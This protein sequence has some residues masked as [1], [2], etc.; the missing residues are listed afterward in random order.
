M[1]VAGLIFLGTTLAA[2]PA[3]ADLIKVGS[4]E[5]EFDPGDGYCALD[6]H[7]SE[8]ERNL[9]EWQSRANAGY[10][11]LLGIFVSCSIVVQLRDGSASDFGQYGILLAPLADGELRE[12]PR[13]SR[14]KFVAELEAALGG[15]V[16]LDSDELEGRINDA[17]RETSPEVGEVGISG[18]KQLGVLHRTNT[19]VFSGLLMHVETDGQAQAVAAVSAT[20]LAKGHMIQYS[21]YSPFV[22]ESIFSALI[23]KLEP[24]MSQVALRNDAASN[25]PTASA[26]A[27]AVLR[28]LNW[29]SVLG[30]AVIG[31]IVG[32][33]VAVIWGL[34]RRF[35]QRSDN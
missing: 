10:N 8:A 2:G 12:M 4:Q 17:L 6:P 5:I 27:G 23:R 24:V 30:K 11:E 14:A 7:A 29:D 25:S 13:M 32:G 18:L 16:D 1:Y 22:D 20:T 3:I 34:G 35:R 31:G 15:G 28:R 33:L 9:I 21:L 26:D 19:G